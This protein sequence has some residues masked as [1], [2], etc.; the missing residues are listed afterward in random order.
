[1][2]YDSGRKIMN[3]FVGLIAKTWYLIDLIDD[4]WKK[5]KTKVYHVTKKYVYWGYDLR[6]TFTHHQAT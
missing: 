4:S 5:L 3:E 6:D 1:M 2:K